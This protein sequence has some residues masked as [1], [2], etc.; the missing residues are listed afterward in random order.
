MK[1][2]IKTLSVI[3]LAVV[4]VI[5]MTACDELFEEEGIDPPTGVVAMKLT[6]GDILVTWYSVS[7]AKKYLI[8]FR[9]NLESADTRHDAGESTTTSF[10][11]GKYS[12]SSRATDAS[13]LFYYV[14]ACSKNS[15]Y[16]DNYTESIYSIPASVDIK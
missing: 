15:N 13:T 7:N 9:T 2:K 14:K 12:Y 1:N 8:S 16:E 6:N 4:V 5:L 10:T 3:F 11:H